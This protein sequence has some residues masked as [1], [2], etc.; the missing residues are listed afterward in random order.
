M[1]HIKKMVFI[2]VTIPLFCFADD[3]VKNAIEHDKQLNIAYNNAIKLLNKNQIKK[4][5]QAQ[6]IWIKYRDAV[7][8]FEKELPQNDHWIRNDLSNSKSLECI[9]RLS[10]A[11][12]KELNTYSKLSK[13]S[14]EDTNPNQI[15][16][17]KS[18]LKN[19][20]ALE[21]W[22]SYGLA[23][24]VWPMELN[25]N[26]QPDLYKR[27][28]F[29]RKNTAQI[30]SELRGNNAVKSNKDLDELVYIYESGFMEEYVWAYIRKSNRIPEN[31]RLDEFKRWM[32]ANLPAHKATINTGVTI[33]PY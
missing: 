4:L 2:L 19:E 9:S 13:S 30:W 5:R 20:N 28:V 31:L 26:G 29:A 18:I 25:E 21:G 27:E 7:C 8:E 24:R 23:L 32:H 22:M 14:G 16:I 17:D 3:R 1:F 10:V 33:P 15:I 6:L 11:R 12:T